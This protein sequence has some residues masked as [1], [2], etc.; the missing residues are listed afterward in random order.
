MGTYI[1]YYV[2]KRL[3]LKPRIHA[4]FF[5]QLLFS[6]FIPRLHKIIIIF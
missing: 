6:V 3:Y 2:R 1:M 5:V 4:N